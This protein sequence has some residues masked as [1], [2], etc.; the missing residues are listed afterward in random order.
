[1]IL[2]TLN[3]KVSPSEFHKIKSLLEWAEI[4]VHHL[5]GVGMGLIR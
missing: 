5:K 4:H 3:M 2:C 1:M